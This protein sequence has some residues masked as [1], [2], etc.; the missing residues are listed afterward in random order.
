VKP[1]RESVEVDTQLIKTK[2]QQWMDIIDSV[3]E[4]ASDDRWKMQ[5]KLLKSI[6]TNLK[7]IVHV[8]LRNKVNTLMKI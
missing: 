5:K 6:K 4:N 2:S 3:I 7:S 1:K 8:V